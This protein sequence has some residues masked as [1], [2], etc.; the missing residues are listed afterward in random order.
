MTRSRCIGRGGGCIFIT[1]SCETFY[2]T[3]A[4]DEDSPSFFFLLF[5]LAESSSTTS[6]ATA[7]CDGSS[8]FSHIVC[9]V[10]QKTGNRSGCVSLRQVGEGGGEKTRASAR[11][12]KEKGDAKPG[13]GKKTYDGNVNRFPNRICETTFGRVL[14]PRLLPRL[15]Q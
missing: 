7:H 3:Q 4:L 12:K 8:R 11:K 2:V 9:C 10:T 15:I 6:Q 1:K 14:T 13:E 5:A